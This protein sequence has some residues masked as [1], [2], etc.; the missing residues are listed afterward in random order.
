[1]RSRHVPADDGQ[2]LVALL[3]IMV[4]VIVL[5]SLLA[6][7][8][9]GIGAHQKRT[10]AADLAALAGAEA[11]RVAQPRLFEPAVLDDGVANP[12][13]LEKAAYLAQ[14]R[15]IALATARRNGAQ[16]V[17]VTFP[18]ASALAPTR[19]AVTIRDPLRVAGRTLTTPAR[20]VAEITPVALPTAGGDLSGEYRGRTSRSPSTA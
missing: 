3:G 15:R 2:A 6:A 14:A 4:L 18:D 20:A 9:S 13:H 5:A 11:L 10:S 12:R 17:T 16:H 19:V 7:F 1:M 8:A